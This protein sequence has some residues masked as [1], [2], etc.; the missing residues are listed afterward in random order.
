MY[1]WSIEKVE[2]SDVY[3]TGLESWDVHKDRQLATGLSLWL[4]L[5]I[6][7]SQCL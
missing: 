6:E 2:D 3:G 1:D 4:I 7:V 5:R